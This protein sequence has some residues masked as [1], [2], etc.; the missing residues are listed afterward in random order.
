MKIIISLCAAL[1][2]LVA[3]GDSDSSTNTNVSN[4]SYEHTTEINGVECT[5]G[6]QTFT[7][8]KAYCLG[9]ADSALNDNCA[10]ELRCGTFKTNGCESL[11]LGVSCD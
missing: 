6:L 1:C 7:T 3:C 9:L 2:F 8:K 11:N 4:F 5:T 10:E